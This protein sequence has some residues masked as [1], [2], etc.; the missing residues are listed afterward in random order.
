[1]ELMFDIETLDLIPSAVVLSIGAVR[2]QRDGTIADRFYRV[3]D[4]QTQVDMGRTINPQTVAWW[5]RQDQDA[6]DEAFSMV[7]HPVELALTEFNEF[8]GQKYLRADAVRGRGRITKFW[9]NGPSFDGVIM[10][11]LYRDFDVTVPWRYNQLR[12][13]RTLG[14]AAGFSFDSFHP[15]IFGV[16]HTPIYDCEFQVEVVT[17]CRRLLAKRTGADFS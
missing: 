3:L 16:P 4:T 12:D 5:M 9:C 14:D 13:Q 17:E 10:E 7:R 1:M 11:S 8:I 15:V 2:F 6:F